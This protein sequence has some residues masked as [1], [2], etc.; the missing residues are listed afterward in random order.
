MLVFAM[1]LRPASLTCFLPICFLGLTGFFFSTKVSALEFGLGMS[2]NQHLVEI[3]DSEDLDQMR[4]EFQSTPYLTPAF[5]LANTPTYFGTSRFGWLLE[6]NIGSY[7][8]TQQR[9]AEGQSVDYGTSIKG[10]FGH[11]NP[12]I[13]YRFGDRYLRGSRHWSLLMGL[14]YGFSFLSVGG[15]FVTD[16]Q[17]DGLQRNVR[18][19]DGMGFFLLP[20]SFVRLHFK[21]WFA[22]FSACFGGPGFVQD[23]YTY[24]LI[25]RTL[26]LGYIFELSAF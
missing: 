3:R 13:F 6:L 11:F 25:F 12:I 7:A 9:N 20:A 23:D 24:R 15:N 5:S 4:A 1:R 2:V 17:P 14:G 26:T 22:G 19:K 10:N 21:H 8:V 16:H 18:I